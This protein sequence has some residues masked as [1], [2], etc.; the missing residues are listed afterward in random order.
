M[1]QDSSL[2]PK[3]NQKPKHVYF[4]TGPY[5]LSS[6]SPEPLINVFFYVVRLSSYQ[7]YYSDIVWLYPPER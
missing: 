1:C 6:L 7:L 2:L 5:L 4:Y 3:Q